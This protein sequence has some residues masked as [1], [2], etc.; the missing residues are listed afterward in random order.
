M[1][2]DRLAEGL[3]HLRIGD[4]LLE[5]RVGDAHAARGDVDAAEFE[6]VEDLLEAASLDAADQAIHR[7]PVVVE[8]QLAGIDAS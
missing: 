3:A 4:S 6:P 7:D 2:A 8:A 1:L 5:R